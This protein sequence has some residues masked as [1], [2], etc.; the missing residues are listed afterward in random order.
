MPVLVPSLYSE[1]FAAPTAP[2]KCKILSSKTQPH[3]LQTNSV[4]TMSNIT[5]PLSHCLQYAELSVECICCSPESIATTP[6]PLLLSLIFLEIRLFLVLKKLFKKTCA[7][8][9]F[10]FEF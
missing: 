3:E 10:Q 6:L 7:A 4:K 1:R 8:I 5:V 9:R 2:S